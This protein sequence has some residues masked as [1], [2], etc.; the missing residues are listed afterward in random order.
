VTAARELLRRYLRQRGKLGERELVLDRLAPAALRRLLAEP[1]AEPRPA[2]APPASPARRTAPPRA[3]AAAPP[4]PPPPAPGDAGLA[5]LTTLTA[6]REVASDCTRCALARTRRSVVFGEGREDADVLVVGEAPGE[7]EDRQGRPFVGRAGRMLD[8]LL[9]SAGFERDEVYI[10]NVLKCRPPRNRDPLPEE[11]AACA[12]YLAGQ[13]ALVRPRVVLAFGAFAARTL[14]GTDASIGRL[15]GRE[16]D[17]QGVP[18]VATYHP[19]ACLRHP[20]WVR[21]VWEDLQRARDLL[22]AA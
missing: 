22:A 14:L 13:V 15:R 10:C 16:H 8:L 5:A 3:P 9:L 20:A 4:A 2:A 6:L 12:P 17:Y 19:A 21:A 7:D 1:A 11:V 18:L